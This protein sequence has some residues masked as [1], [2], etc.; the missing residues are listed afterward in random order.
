MIKWAKANIPG[1]RVALLYPN[2]ESGWVFDK[3]VSEQMGKVGYNVVNKELVER[4]IKDFQPVLTRILANNPDVIDLGPTLSATAGLIVRQARELGYKKA[5]IVLGGG[6]AR[7]IVTAAGPEASEGIL[8]MVYADPVNPAYKPIADRY[9]QKFNALPNE[10]IVNYY[11]G[12]VALMKA[13]QL[14]G[15]PNNAVKV[16]EA[17]PKVFPLKSLQGDS[18]TFGGKDTIGVDAQVFSKNY[19]AVVKKGESVVVGTAN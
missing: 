7:E 10:L 18:L 14:A 13:I 12:A 15:D 4:S 3:M 9:R 17:F 16:R 1:D 8:H 5:F 19:I 11:D 6:G 2:D